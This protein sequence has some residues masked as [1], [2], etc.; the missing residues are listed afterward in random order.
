MKRHGPYFSP[1]YP[2]FTDLTRTIATKA[3]GDPMANRRVQFLASR[4]PLGAIQADG[5]ASHVFVSEATG[6][7]EC[8][9]AALRRRRHV[10]LGLMSLARH[11]GDSSETS[12]GFNARMPQRHC[13]SGLPVARRAAPFDKWGGS[14][15]TLMYRA[16]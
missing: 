6:T 1:V 12:S 15:T 3:V 14:V 7:T 8:Q 2:C 9:R 4:G 5:L 11:S 13:W 10:R 16:P